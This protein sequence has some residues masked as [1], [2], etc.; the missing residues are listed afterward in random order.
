LR[1]RLHRDAKR[2]LVLFGEVMR[3]CAEPRADDHGTWI[4]DE[5]LDAYEALHGAGHAHSLEVWVDGRLAGGIYGVALGRAFFGE[6][7]FSRVT[8]G[9]KLAIAYLAAQLAR[10]EVPFIDCQ[11]PRDHLA[12]LGGRE[13]PRRD[14]LRRLGPLAIVDVGCGT[15]AAGAAWA[16]HAG[17]GA[18]LAAYDSHP[19][20]VEETRATIQAFGLKE[21]TG[22]FRFSVG[23]VGVEELAAAMDRLEAALRAVTLS[24]AEVLGVA[25]LTGSLSAGKLA[26]VVAWAACIVWIVYG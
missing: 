16:V 23:A 19:W 7:M 9:S 13:V 11:V 15:G 24:A 17:A 12:S 8:D 21:D 22:W 5:M 20:A 6:S 4:T 2:I 25:D 1:L 26:N 18:T 14:F 10:W 3:A